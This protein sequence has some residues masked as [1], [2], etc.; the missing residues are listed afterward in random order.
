[1]IGIFKRLNNNQLNAKM[2]LQVHDE[3][4]F[5]VQEDEL[6]NLKKI[7]VEEME[8]AADLTIPLVVD[9]GI[10]KNWLEAH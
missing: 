9:H 1:M 5:E 7:V 2:I 6:A 10:G 8:G 4:I 3:L